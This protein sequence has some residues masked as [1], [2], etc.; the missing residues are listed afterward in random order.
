LSSLIY[1]IIDLF[2]YFLKTDFNGL[3][4]FL[5]DNLIYGEYL[6]FGMLQL[7]VVPYHLLFYSY[8]ALI[9]VFI[10]L[11]YIIDNIYIYFE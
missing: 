4:A 9:Y 8:I 6:H 10:K 11:T 5:E 3:W 1:F 7:D 2:Q